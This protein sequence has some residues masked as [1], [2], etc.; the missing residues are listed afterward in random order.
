MQHSKALVHLRCFS[1]KVLAGQIQTCSSYIRD[2][3]SNLY[4]QN[5]NVFQ[6]SACVNSAALSRSSVQ[7]ETESTTITRRF[8]NSAYTQLPSHQGAGGVPVDVMNQLQVFLHIQTTRAT[9]T[10]VIRQDRDGR[11]MGGGLGVGVW[12][13]WGR[14]AFYE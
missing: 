4:N 12:G 9:G 13:C 7:L 5:A 10:P 8:L 14:C 6:C 2:L 3:G 11:L 1:H